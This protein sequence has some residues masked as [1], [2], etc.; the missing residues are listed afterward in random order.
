ML[1]IFIAILICLIFLAF[2]ILGEILRN[3]FTVAFTESPYRYPHGL[4]LPPL[5]QAILPSFPLNL[6]RFY[7]SCYP[8]CAA[9]LVILILTF[10]S[11]P[12]IKPDRFASYCLA[13]CFSFAFY[14]WL[15]AI[16]LAQPYLIL[17]TGIGPEGPQDTILNTFFV[18][19]NC[20]LWIGA[21]LLFLRAIFKRSRQTS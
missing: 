19:M 13:I 2:G 7:E 20:L 3:E 18:V 6:G 9:V 21:F 14:F 15:F 12:I 11:P 17:L 8:F 16:A 4:P 10:Q 5:T 1:R